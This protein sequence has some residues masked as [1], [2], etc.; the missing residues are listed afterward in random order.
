[1]SLFAYMARRD[2]A[3]RRGDGHVIKSLFGL[4][5]ACG[6]HGSSAG[7]ATAFTI[8]AQ[9]EVTLLARLERAGA[10]NLLKGVWGKKQKLV[11]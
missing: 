4:V 9:R 6:A 2:R 8:A 1:M 5:L 11:S 10:A 3:A 7:V